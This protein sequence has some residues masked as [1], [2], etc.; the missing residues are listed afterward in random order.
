MSYKITLKEFDEKI[1]NYVKD[2]QETLNDIVFNTNESK[3]FINQ[4]N[5]NGEDL[6]NI[7][8]QKGLY[9]FELNLESEKLVGIKNGTKIL[10][11]AKDW[12]KKVKTLFFRLA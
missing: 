2:I 8:N 1:S 12:S 7:K 4:E 11:F 9:L 3:T 10:N 5:Y 6:F